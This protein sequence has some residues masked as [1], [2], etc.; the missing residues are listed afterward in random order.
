MIK[1]LELADDERPYFLGMY[2]EQPDAVGHANGTEADSINTALIYI[3][4][5]VNYLLSRLDRKGY[6]GCVNIV[7]VS[8]HGM[9]RLRSDNKRLADFFD[10]EDTN[11]FATEGVISHLYFEDKSQW[12]FSCC[13]TFC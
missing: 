10:L 1:W 5:M 6:L 3:D 9:Q 13:S 11:L 12:G 7:L 8:D 2:F 4:A